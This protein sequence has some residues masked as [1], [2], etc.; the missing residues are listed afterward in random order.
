MGHLMQASLLVLD[1]ERR[2]ASLLARDSLFGGPAIWPR[3]RPE[4]GLTNG[5]AWRETQAAYDM[6]C[7]LPNAG[8][9]EVI[10]VS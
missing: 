4:E 2:R 6:V 3:I 5:Q 10:I 8:Q 7:G 1:G 9:T